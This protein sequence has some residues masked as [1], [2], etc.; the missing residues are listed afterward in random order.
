M[1]ALPT[2]TFLSHQDG[3]VLTL[4]LN[5]PD[6][7]NALTFE[8]YA[9]LRDTLASLQHQDSVH[10]VVITGAGRGFCS[11]GDAKEIIGELVSQPP[12]QVLA[13]ARMTCDVIRNIRMLRKPVVAAIN[14]VAAGAGAV[15]A[16]ACDFRIM[17]QGA[18]FAFLFNKVGLAGSDMGASF[19]LPRVVGL[20]RATHMLMLG[21]PVAADQ[22]LDWG[23]CTQVVPPAQL[24]SAANTLAA[25]L[26]SGP[27]LATGVT[28]EMLNNMFSASFHDALDAEARAQAL[29]MTMDDFKEFAD[30][31][32]GK[33]PPAFQGH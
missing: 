8:V 29:C 1:T 24:L 3:G 22:A 12:A 32:K 13:F 4:T 5:R 7:L 27:R 26:A 31:W 28:K 19:L 25:T 33:R 10:V 20:G 15:V 14:G 17:A 18:S 21:E 9:E 30:A 23:L 2:K 11:G 16:L 6:K